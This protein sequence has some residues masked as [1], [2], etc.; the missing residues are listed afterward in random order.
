M[1][2]RY[3]PEFRLRIN[4]ED[5]PSAL[6]A[7]IS[8]VRYQDGLNAADRVEVGIANVDLRWLTKH[9]RGLGLP[10]FP[11]GIRIGGAHGA[12]TPDGLFDVDNTLALEMG[13]A[14][15]PLEEMFVGDVTGLNASFPGGSIPGMTLV[16]HDRLHRLSQG[17]YSRGFGPLPD[18]ILAAILGAENLLVPAIDP[19]VA[20]DASALAALSLAFNGAGR[21]QAAQSDLQLLE[22][23]ARDYDADFWVEGDVLFLAR[24]MPKE[25]EPRLTLTWGESLL[26]FSPSITTVGRVVG[27]ARRFTLREIPLS[28]LV[29]ISWDFE[30]EAIR[31][32]VVPGEAASQLKQTGEPT[33]IRIDEPIKTP[34]DIAKSALAMAKEL[35]GKI[36]GRLKGSGSAVGDPRIRAGAVIR[37][38]SLGPDFSGDYRV[39]SASHSIDSGGYRTSFQVQREII[40]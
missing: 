28:F 24:F 19:A 25:Y 35:R 17:S 39:V 32:Q 14:P 30:R 20:V 21:K 9:V 6:R 7:S 22:Q 1:N 8:S 4:D 3:A 10:A 2:A 33:Q 40:P 38:E 11:T 34:S 29:S 27:V 16:A 31:L 23:I 12:A 36:N 18:A 15:G 37:L 26:D 13:Y 5:I